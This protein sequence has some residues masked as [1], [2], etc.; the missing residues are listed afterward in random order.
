MAHCVHRH[1]HVLR[2]DSCHNLRMELE[3]EVNVKGRKGGKKRWKKQVVGKSMNVDLSRD[4]VLC[5]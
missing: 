2:I 1:V 4:D 5:R 3:F